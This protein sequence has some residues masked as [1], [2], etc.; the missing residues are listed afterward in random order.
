MPIMTAKVMVCANSNII[1]E[2]KENF[3]AADD[4]YT[5]KRQIIGKRHHVCIYSDH[6]DAS[7]HRMVA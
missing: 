6:R 1:K 3:I 5:Y 2:S 7:C 4:Y